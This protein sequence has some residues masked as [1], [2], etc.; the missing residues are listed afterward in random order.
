MD[1]RLPTQTTGYK[2]PSQR[3][4]VSSEA[5]VGRAVYCPCCGTEKLLK[6]Q[7]NKPAAD[8]YCGQCSEEFELKSNR[9]T[10]KE[11]IVDGAY[12]SM[13]ARVSSQNNPNLFLMAYDGQEV[14]DFL[15]IP[16]YFF[17]T[18]TIQ[19]RPPLSPTARR[20]GWVG[21]N[22]LLAS[23][24][25]AGRIFLLQNKTVLPKERVIL[26]WRKTCF[27]RD[28]LEQKRS[29]L[30]DVMHCIDSLNSERF[31]LSDVYKFERELSQKHPENRHVR[32]KIRQQLQFLRDKGYIRFLGSGEYALS[33]AEAELPILNHKTLFFSDLIPEGSFEDGC[34]PVYDLQA[35]ATAFGEQPTPSV[36]GWKRMAGRRCEPDMFIAQVV[37]RSMEP[38]IKD[39]SWCLF[40]FNPEG[41]R[42]GVYLIESRL[43]TDPET[44][45]SFT[46]KRYYSKKKQMKDGRW[47]H[48]EIRLS[49]DN[50]AFKEI[51]L[52]NVSGDDFRVVAEFVCCL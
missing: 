47:R 7:N 8:F 28:E 24:P 14:M 37:G 49:P 48:E 22:I 33:N 31:S 1:I 3:I 16:K 52:K 5:W 13:M 46:I 25:N 10:I 39:G 51:V 21:C 45:Q 30:F 27:L 2:S 26:E 9:G 32:D 20:A 12:A 17:T 36:K 50:K 6:F 40:R 42:H 43:V 4:R 18:D 41:S 19:K 23:V 15:V 29:W 34:L 35:V 44:Q 11:K 38:T